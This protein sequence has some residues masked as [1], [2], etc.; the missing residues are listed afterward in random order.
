MNES[1]N[2]SLP[3][4]AR[5]WLAEALGLSAGESAFPWQEALL[6][7]FSR[8]V[9]AGAL[10]I[11]TGLGKTALIAIWLVARA[12][13]APLPRRVVYVVDRRA[14]VDQ[15]TEV[16]EALRAW[17]ERTPE[18]KQALGLKDRQLPISTLRGQ[19]ADNKEWLDDPL[20]PAIVIG[21]VDMVGS[22]LLFAGYGVSVKMR[23]FHAGL[24]GADTLVAL[25]EAHLVPPF[26]RL[27]QAVASDHD[28]LAPEAALRTLIP[29]FRTMSLS[30][31]GSAHADASFGLTAADLAHPIVAK[32]LGSVKRL[33]VVTSV[34]DDT[35]SLADK[36]AAQAFELSRRCT[37]SLR[38]I[39][40]CTKREDARKAC[41]A[42][43]K[44]ADK[45]RR[46]APTTL[47]A[48]TELFVG[49]RRVYDRQAAARNLRE[50]GFI[51]GSTA[52]R[53]FTS[54]VFSTSAGEVGVDLD[55][56][57]MVCDLVEWERM[58]QRLGRVNRRGEREADVV[59]L[60]ER[61]SKEAL[62]AAEKEDAKRDPKERVLAA[63]FE[64][65]AN[66]RELLH[67]L[68]KLDGA[69]DASPGAIRELKKTHAALIAKGST[70][71]PL[72]PALTRAVVDAWAMTSLKEHTGRP[73]VAPWLRGWIEEEEPQTSV[74]WRRF[75]PQRRQKDQEGDALLRVAPKDVAE[76]FE[77]APPQLPE[78][79]DAEV[80]GVREWLLERAELVFPPRGEKPNEKLVD[81]PELPALQRE[82][83]VA[84]LRSPD[85]DI[86]RELT[87]AELTFEHDKRWSDDLDRALTGNTLIVDARL[88]GLDEG[89]LDSKRSV[90]AEP[91]LKCADGD[92]ACEMDDE[93]AKIPFQ[94]VPGRPG[95]TPEGAHAESWNPRFAFPYI[96]NGK[97]ET[98][99]ELRI[100]RWE[101]TAETEDD[102]SEGHP[103]SLAAHQSETEKF[104]RAFADR[105]RLPPDYAEMLAVAA[106][107]HDEGKKADVWQRAFSAP[108]A[109]RPYAKTRGPLRTNLLNHYRHELGSLPHAEASERLKALAPELRDLALHLIIAHHGFGRPYITT[110][111]CEDAP[112]SKLKQRAGEIALRFLRLQERWGPWGL[113]W[114]ESLLRAADQ[115]AS[116]ANDERGRQ[117]KRKAKSNG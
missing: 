76:F 66:V 74:I 81:D 83:V 61:E 57:H 20:S 14:V 58:V 111:G 51:A 82:S 65:R 99:R 25:D 13:R 18:V 6:E 69:R 46:S 78:V 49:G 35:R 27:L 17:V 24:M 52:A 96:V 106:S 40:F 15:A 104:A 47:V 59:V 70:P 112:P 79:L 105:L 21:T 97:G 34:E 55:A 62:A 93:D 44:L 4:H 87:I 53:D 16:A 12:L 102:R 92:S 30:A 56:D 113:A 2:T 33:T 95:A 43:Q 31:T 108:Q 37:E 68:P 90:D 100:D 109:G 64:R 117:E 86:I 75:L 91:I 22:R 10:D 11:P 26:E 72:R 9:I 80:R 23:A 110:E 63:G 85:G 7:Q 98:V 5:R 89:L 3:E 1:V 32:R 84:L 19:H 116:R 94:I 28:A 38:I 45:E 54:F 36:L 39:V 60:D 50:L 101:T 41:E 42:L 48:R 29:P 103:Q 115:T 71:A 114:W 88:G 73:E 67:A 77:A 107:L 8:G